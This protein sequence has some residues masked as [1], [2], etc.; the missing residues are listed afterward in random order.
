MQLIES[1]N[2][3]QEIRESRDLTPKM[4]AFCLLVSQGSALSAAYRQ[5]H[6][7][8]A[9]TKAHTV[10][11]HAHVLAKRCAGRIAELRAAIADRVVISTAALRMR[12]LEI[13]SAAPLTQVR[14]FNCRWCPTDGKH[15]SWADAEDFCAAVEKWKASK[16]MEP[17]P[18][19]LGGFTWDAFAPP[20]PT[21]RKCM[22]AGV[23][24]LYVPDTTQLE[25]AAAAAYAGASIDARTGTIEIHQHDQQQAA[26]ELHRMVPGAIAP[27]QSESLS[28]N[29]DVPA[30]PVSP[31]AVLAAYHSLRLVN[32]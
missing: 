6:D 7:V 28:V 4:E 14:V 26:A 5:T 27:K 32:K 17:R 9:D 1:T 16:G 10:N 2:S 31:E 8:G 20:S 22:G 12:Q 30:P 21:C 18:S 25:G 29:L 11:N 24:V 19:A 23:K 15:Y 3:G 13:A